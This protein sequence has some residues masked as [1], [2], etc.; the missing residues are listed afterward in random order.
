MLRLGG[1]HMTYQLR[2]RSPA[3]RR[4]QADIRTALNEAAV[5]VE[6]DW[7]AFTYE[8]GV[9]EIS[10]PDEKAPEVDWQKL[11]DLLRRQGYVVDL[12]VP[13]GEGRLE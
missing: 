12:I 5:V 9:V 10:V 8:E 1:A 3:V 7:P 4:A 11:A 6:P 13:E 2:V